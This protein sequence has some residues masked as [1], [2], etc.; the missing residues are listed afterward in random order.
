MPKNKEGGYDKDHQPNWGDPAEV[1]QFQAWLGTQNN[2][3]QP[4]KVANSPVH[5][6]G[7]ETGIN[8][9]GDLERQL[10]SY[11]TGA[12]LGQK[13]FFDDPEM[14]RLKKIR[15]EYAK[16]YSGDELGGIR[17]TARGEIAGA[18]AAQ[19][20]KLQ[21][22]LARGGVGGARAAAISSAQG[23][24]GQ[25]AINQAETKMALDSAQMQRQGAA[26]LQDFIFRQ[27]LGKAGMAAGFG[28]MGSSDYAAA[29]GRAANTGGGKK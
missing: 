7:L 22:S 19:Q 12:A 1:R 3:G 8:I 28:A 29:Q 20:R 10:N 17:Q 2:P 16:G 15:E 23:R 9:T 21:S 26:D 4:V 18:Q 11:Y 27:K 25:K 5:Q 6:F 13:E 24:E 14:Q